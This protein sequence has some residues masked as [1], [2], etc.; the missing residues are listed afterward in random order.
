M[1]TTIKSVLL[2]TA[3]FSVGVM[4]SAQEKKEVKKAIIKTV[5]INNGDTI[6]NEQILEGD[7]ALNHVKS[8]NM[9]VKVDGKTII[10]KNSDG[11][12]K[13]LNIND[14]KKEGANVM[15]F[16]TETDDG[17]VKTQTKKVIVCTGDTADCHKK[18]MFKG[19]DGKTFIIKMDGKDGA[20]NWDENMHMPN[21]SNVEVDEEIIDGKKVKTI[22]ITS[23]IEEPKDGKVVQKKVSKSAPGIDSE[24]TFNVFP[25]PN[26]GNVTI[27][28]NVKKQS[29]VLITI[30]DMAGKTI[31][32]E[33]VMN[34]QG[35]YK[36]EFDLSNQPTGTYIATATYAGNKSVLQ[37]M[38]K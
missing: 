7:D 26:N 1:N 8:M 14:L 18:M 23:E 17:D 10:I 27:S 38:K 35:E 5:E 29:D 13:T 3:L 32:E 15:I 9:D 24:K 6:V 4:A 16:D 22:R 28:L 37:F 33:K 36:K 2:T 25:N 34:F 11:T 12:T 20:I 19:D 21:G 30:T 31:M